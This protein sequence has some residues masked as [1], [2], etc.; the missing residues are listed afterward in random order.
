V[1]FLKSLG[2]FRIA[3]DVIDTSGEGQMIKEEFYQVIGRGGGF[4]DKWERGRG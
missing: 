3:F 4:G 2:S 1:S